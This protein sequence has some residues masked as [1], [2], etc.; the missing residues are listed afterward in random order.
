MNPPDP[1][2][3]N[4]DTHRAIL[5]AAWT[6]LDTQGW[7]AVTVDRIA[8]TAGVGKQTIYRW[9]HDK[10]DVVFESFLDQARA[11][12]PA[13]RAH[14]LSELLREQAHNF[15]R[16]YV[17]TPLGTHLRELLGAAQ[18][19]PRLA[20]ALRGHWFTPRRESLRQALYEA[21]QA[22]QIRADVDPDTVLDLLFGP[23]HYRLLI[24]YAP[25]DSRY[26]DTVTDLTLAAIVSGSG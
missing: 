12:V 5:D 24:G 22:N 19:D 13:S 6:L 11:H 20:D 17:D 18:H 25:I 8:A 4:P 23:L 16:L 2:R 26:A 1:A 9:W 7:Q 15:V 10:A 14:G 21:Q 3:R